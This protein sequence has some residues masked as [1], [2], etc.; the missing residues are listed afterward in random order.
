MFL[1]FNHWKSPSN[2]R[3]NEALSALLDSSFSN[4][5]T[6]SNA[7]SLLTIESRWYKG[8]FRT[9]S[10]INFAPVGIVPL[11]LYLRNSRYLFVMV[12]CSP[13]HSLIRIYSW[14][15]LISPLLKLGCS[16][17][18]PSRICH[19]KSFFMTRCDNFY[20]GREHL[21]LVCRRSFLV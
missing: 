15:R 16:F 18:S 10:L 1:T 8:C 2:I 19:T 13:D 9:N 21:K 5:L 11:A 6:K 20:L 4:M 17:T 3:L 14:Q 7:I 12:W